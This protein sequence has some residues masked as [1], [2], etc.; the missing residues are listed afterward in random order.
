MYL[1][2]KI[3]IHDW[4]KDVNVMKERGSVTEKLQDLI[5]EESFASKVERERSKR[6]G[7]PVGQ[8]QERIF[9]VC[10]NLLIRK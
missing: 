9:D 3:N 5:R 1:A 7:S 6:W 8:R 2:S 4:S 10:K